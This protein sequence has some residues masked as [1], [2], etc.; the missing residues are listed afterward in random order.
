MLLRR[1][2]AA[3]RDHDLDPFTIGT[4]TVKPCTTPRSRLANA[5]SAQLN[6]HAKSRDEE[7]QPSHTN[8]S[9]STLIQPAPP[10]S[11]SPE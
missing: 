8:N 10:T 2:G 3:S 4:C 1:K 9:T 7:L 11:T 6:E 5:H